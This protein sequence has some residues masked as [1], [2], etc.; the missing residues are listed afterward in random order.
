MISLI[1]LQSQEQ[2][3][4]IAI[5]SNIVIFFFDLAPAVI[6]LKIL[7]YFTF[8]NLSFNDHIRICKFLA[9]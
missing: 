1:Q 4:N 6:R 3:S 8:I 9:I 7:A 5:N 2:F